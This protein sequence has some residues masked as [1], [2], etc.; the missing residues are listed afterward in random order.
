MKSISRIIWAL[1][2]VMLVSM[3]AARAYALTGLDIMKKYLDHFEV[4]D[5]INKADMT[6]ISKGGK[7]RQRSITIMTKEYADDRHKILV[8]F[9][10][11]ENIR[12]AGLLI[13][14]NKGRSDD[15]WLYLPALK[16][17]KKI[18]TSERSHSFMGS[19]FSYEDLHPEVLE[20]YRYEL[21]GSE[22]VGGHD[23]Y[24]VQAVPV[25]K[26]KLEETGY[27]KRILWIRKDLSFR[28]KVQYFD[29]KGNLLKTETDGGLVDIGGGKYRMNMITMMND[30]T[31][32]STV[33]HSKSR[34]IDSG[35]PDSRFTTSHLEQG[36]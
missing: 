24:R 3:V 26:R 29:K 17:I 6:L 18:S 4:A 27:G 25:S 35:I 19:E 5:E 9:T 15:E 14:E 8:R 16:K 11:P 31:G 23:C 34:K 7:K 33:L 10:A 2:I 28:I 20:D 36:A 30:R 21:L 12:G 1:I 13:V 32:K 22:M